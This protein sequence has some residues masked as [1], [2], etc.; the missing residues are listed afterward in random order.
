MKEVPVTYSGKD[1]QHLDATGLDADLFVGFAQCRG[2]RVGVGRVEFA[3]RQGDLTRVA[4]QVRRAQGEQQAQAVAHH[5]RQQHSRM[6]R[7]PVSKPLFAHQLRHPFGRPGKQRAQA[8]GR[9][10]LRVGRIQ[11]LAAELRDDGDVTRIEQGQRRRGHGSRAYDRWTGRLACGRQPCRAWWPVGTGD[12]RSKKNRPLGAVLLRS[13]GLT[14]P[15]F[16]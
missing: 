7:R 3:A 11:A 16:P 12:R 15:A 9:Q 10:A 1:P 14:R 6:G 13:R 4:G 2:H 8:L 5:Q